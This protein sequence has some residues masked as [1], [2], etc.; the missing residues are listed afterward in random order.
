M[1]KI[2]PF[3]CVALKTVENYPFPITI[4]GS[5]LST[6][7]SSKPNRKSSSYIIV[8]KKLINFYFKRLFLIITCNMIYLIIILGFIQCPCPD[9][10]G[11]CR[12][13]G[14]DRC[15]N[16]VSSFA[17]SS[18]ICVA[19]N[20]KIVNCITYEDENTCLECELGYSVTEDG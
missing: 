19:V 5:D 14:G 13:C 17:N 6:I 7:N 9:T 16:C 8:S 1:A 4:S 10:D 3:L 18:G 11:F 15:L 2:L 20:T 12:R